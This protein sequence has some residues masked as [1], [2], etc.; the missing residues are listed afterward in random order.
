MALCARPLRFQTATAAASLRQTSMLDVRKLQKK[1]VL[2]SSSSQSIYRELTRS[3]CQQ[4]IAD[5]REQ[6]RDVMF[7]LE[8]QEKLANTTD[9]SQEEIQEGQVIV[10]ATASPSA[11]GRKGHKKRR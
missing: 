6:L 5:L 8:A 10:G 3:V 4:E 11:V 9:V 7:F 1:V 2:S